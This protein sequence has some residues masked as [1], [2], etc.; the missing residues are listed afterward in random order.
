[1]A[2]R[3][4]RYGSQGTRRPRKQKDGV[5]DAPRTEPYQ[6]DRLGPQ[7]AARDALFGDF[8]TPPEVHLRVG[9]LPA[10][11][12]I[13]EI[14]LQRDQTGGRV[15][16]ASTDARSLLLLHR[17]HHRNHRRLLSFANPDTHT[18]TT[19]HV[20]VNAIDLIGSE[21]LRAER[22]SRPAVLIR[23]T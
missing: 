21:R 11:A 22:N 17:R 10:H 1:M 2:F 20:Y 12:Q 14:Q 4:F 3:Q 7:G 15:R 23:I 6:D 16:I 9:L 18:H 13:E 5:Q 8:P 19:I